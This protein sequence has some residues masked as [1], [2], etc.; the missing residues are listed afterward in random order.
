MCGSL[1]SPERGGE[2][3]SEKENDGKRDVKKGSERR[4]KMK[5][6]KGRE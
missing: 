6:G 2:W 3:K 5:E 1:P 4:E